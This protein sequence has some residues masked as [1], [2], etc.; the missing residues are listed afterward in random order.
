MACPVSMAA[1]TL[2][3]EHAY[4][5]AYTHVCAQVDRDGRNYLCHE[6]DCPAHKIG[7]NY[8]DHKCMG[9]NYFLS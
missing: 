9:H 1:D 5:H 3:P 4:T 2:E 7:H 8:I 6:A